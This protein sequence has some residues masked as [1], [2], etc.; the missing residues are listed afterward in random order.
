MNQMLDGELGGF[1]SEQ[2]EVWGVQATDDFI[3]QGVSLNDS[4]KK[5]AVDNSLNPKQIARIVEV[6]NNAAF[7]ALYKTAEDK[8]AEFPLA[9]TKEIVKSLNIKTETENPDIPAQFL[10]PPPS[11]HTKIACKTF[12]DFLTIEGMPKEATEAINGKEKI[13]NEIRSLRESIETS[14]DSY[15]SSLFKLDN[16]RKEA[17]KMIQN[18]ILDKRAS[19]PDLVDAMSEIIP[20]QKATGMSLLQDVVDHLKKT[21]AAT[22]EALFDRHEGVKVVNGSHPLFGLI[23]TIDMEENK[24]SKSLVVGEMAEEKIRELKKSLI[25][26]KIF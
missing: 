10:N 17:S 4:I 12:D 24:G 13:L 18:L 7:L 22:S 11:S 25:K 23:K 16:L 15:I 1:G 8:T 14:R 5:L 6:A 3:K 26:N 21:A 20:E 19:A 2:F 9:D